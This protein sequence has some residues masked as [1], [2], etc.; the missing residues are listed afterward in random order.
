M[1]YSCTPR[2]EGAKSL[3]QGNALCN[4]TPP[5]SGKPQRG[6]I[7]R[8]SPSVRAPFAP[9]TVSSQQTPFAPRTVSSQQNPF[10]QRT[11]NS[12]QMS[13]LRLDMTGK[14]KI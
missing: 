10:A 4:E 3:A 11:V 9:R 8:M 12:Q 13:R 5:S 6:V 7:K 14:S 2:P 1:I